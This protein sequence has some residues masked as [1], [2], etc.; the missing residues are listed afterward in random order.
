MMSRRVALPVIAAV[1]LAGGSACYQDDSSNG[2][3]SRKPLAKVLLTDAPFPYDS[4]TSVNLYVVRIE[5]S[6]Q[7]DATGGDWIV[8][9]EPRR[10]FDLLQLQQGTTAILCEGEGPVWPVLNARVTVCSRSPCDS[11]SATN[12]VASGRSDNAGRYKVAFVRAGTYL[13]RIERADHPWLDAVISPAVQVT[14]GDTATL[15][16]VLPR[17]GSGGAYIKISGPTS[18]GVGGTI[19]LRVAVG[20]A[21]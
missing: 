11:Q 12:V 19:L 21:R 18:V 7:M 16:V 13:V 14:T 2:P 5:A 9:A 3:A 1:L 8:I 10:T 15:S 20:D 6:T 17:A 4:V